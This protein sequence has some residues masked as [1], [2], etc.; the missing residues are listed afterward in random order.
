MCLNLV[1]FDKQDSLLPLKCCSAGRR[2]LRK[3][4]SFTGSLPASLSDF[5]NRAKGNDGM[6]CVFCL[7]FQLAC[8]CGTAACFLCCKCCPKIK[9]STSTRFMYALYFILVTII[10]CIM[11]ST[12]VANEMKTHVSKTAEHTAAP[13]RKGGSFHSSSCTRAVSSLH[14]STSKPRWDDFPCSAS[15]CRLLTR[16]V[17]FTTGRVEGHRTSSLPPLS[18][19]RNALQRT[20]PRFA[21][22]VMSLEAC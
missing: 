11:M 7:T 5:C 15:S 9:Q 1:T 19:C 17:C 8:C 3:F 20:H 21:A 12:T 2:G 13:G 4:W 18:S 22:R 10:C 6:T 16:R 14:P